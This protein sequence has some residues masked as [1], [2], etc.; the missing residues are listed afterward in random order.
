MID[1]PNACKE[2]LSFKNESVTKAL[3]PKIMT[4]SKRNHILPLVG[5]IIAEDLFNTRALDH[6]FPKILKEYEEGED[7]LL[8]IQIIIS[9]ITDPSS[10][11]HALSLL[12]DHLSN[13]KKLQ[14]LNYF[15]KNTNILYAGFI[16]RIL[17]MTLINLSSSDPVITN[18]LP[19]TVKKILSTIEKE[20][21]P[22][23][24]EIFKEK[25][26]YFKEIPL[27]NIPKGLEP[28]LPLIQNSLM[29]GNSEIKDLAAKSYCEVIE[30]T[31]PDVLS[32]YAVMIVGPLI[33]VLSEKVSGSVKVSILDALFLLIQKTSMKLKPFVSQLQSTFTKS[34]A[35]AESGVRDSAGR[36][37]IELLKLKPRLDLLISDLKAMQG[38]AEVIEKS[39]FILQKITEITE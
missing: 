38:S 6:L 3:L 5:N 27:F 13:E 33:R 21:Y 39:Q 26:N 25:L 30:R 29:Y 11:H 32:G 36:N 15:A 9:S 35:H 18:L 28:F 17:E 24:F 2:L 12:H 37:I 22:D 34:L 1:Y 7:L 8:P 16:D 31:I 14:V 23:Y 4:A 19:E 10:L 20:Q